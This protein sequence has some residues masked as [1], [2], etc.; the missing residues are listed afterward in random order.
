MLGFYKTLSFVITNLMNLLMVT[1]YQYCERKTYDQAGRYTFNSLNTYD[2][3]YRV[4]SLKADSV[5]LGQGRSLT[6]GT[7]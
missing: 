3:L 6:N 1:Y 4:S 5:V 2:D 7:G